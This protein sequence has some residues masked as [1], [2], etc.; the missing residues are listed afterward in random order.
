MLTSAFKEANE[1]AGKSDLRWSASTWMTVA[2]PCR[3]A[4]SACH[5]VPHKQL[6]YNCVRC[7]GAEEC[8]DDVMEVCDRSKMFVV[9][10]LLDKRVG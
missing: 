7:Q 1:R 6:R 10:A 9:E 4:Q 5:L 2:M 3:L 8:N